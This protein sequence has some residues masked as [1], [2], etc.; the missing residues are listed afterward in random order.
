MEDKW[1]LPG[2]RPRDITR[3]LRGCDTKSEG[4]GRAAL[5]SCCEPGAALGAVA[6]VVLIDGSIFYVIAIMESCMG[7]TERPSTRPHNPQGNP[8][9]SH[10]SSKTLP[11]AARHDGKAR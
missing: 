5:P 1:G 10:S 2:S 7:G 11:R 8:P 9:W 3:V 4:L 6:L